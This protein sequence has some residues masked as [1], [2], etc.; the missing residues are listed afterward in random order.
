MPLL[1]RQ[2]FG[3]ISQN[4]GIIQTHSNNL[5]NPFHFACRKWSLYNNPQY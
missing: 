3:K 4:P 5:N 2:F 1:H